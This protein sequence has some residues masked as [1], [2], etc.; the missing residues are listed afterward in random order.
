MKYIIYFCIVFSL[1]PAVI[2]ASTPTSMTYT[3]PPAA[4]TPLPTLNKTQ[5]IDTV[6]TEKVQLEISK[7]KSL[8]GQAVSAASHEQIISL[9]GSVE[10]RDQE[11]DAIKAA[12][13]VQGVK[14]VKSELTIK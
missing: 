12:Q 13:S 1:F 6:L 9:Q 3:T 4:S 2:L 8:Q 10:T 7:V 14:E 5:N 11:K